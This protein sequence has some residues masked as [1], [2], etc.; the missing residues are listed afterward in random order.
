MVATVS[1]R[2]AV[3]AGIGRSDFSIMAAR[4]NSLFLTSARPPNVRKREL[5]YVVQATIFIAIVIGSHRQWH[6]KRRGFSRGRSSR[7]I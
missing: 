3:I 7:D 1:S 4:R 2:D 5:R 6:C